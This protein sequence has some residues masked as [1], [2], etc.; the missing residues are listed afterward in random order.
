LY[1]NV[2]E[3]PSRVIGALMVKP[4][5]LLTF[6]VS[7]MAPPLARSRLPPEVLPTV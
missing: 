1:W 7:E 5:L 6:V 2:Y 3:A 4:V